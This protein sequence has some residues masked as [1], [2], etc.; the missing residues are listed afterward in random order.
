MSNYTF[1]TH[2][3]KRLSDPDKTPVV[4]VACGSF[5]PITY[6]HMRM[7]EMAQDYVRQ[8]TDFE[9]VGGY[10]SPVGDGYKKP[11]LLNA[12]RRVEMCRLA[13]DQTS[14]WLMVDDW[15]A[16]QTEYQRTALVLD[17]FDHEIN[18]VRGG[19]DDMEGV[20]HQVRVMLLAGS[21]LIHTMSEPGVWSPADLEH[22][23][24]RYG[25]FIIERAGSDVD[26]ALESLSA[27][28]DNI[29]VIRQMI[30]NDVSSTKIRLFLRRGM[31]IQYLLPASVIEYIE[32]NRLYLDENHP[33]PLPASAPDKERN[34]ERSSSKLSPSTS[35]SRPR[36]RRES[37][38]GL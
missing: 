2:R 14:R 26:E 20:K 11:G 15:E 18:T 13:C 19:V 25:C 12:S 33:G 22:I 31:S 7:F 9:V 35:S 36:A 37:A 3:L 4:L 17:H 34:G 27:W 21:D 8:E 38:S 10:M 23:L 16:L 30:Q 24:G 28:H 6:A 5:S 1:F 29:Y 32:Q